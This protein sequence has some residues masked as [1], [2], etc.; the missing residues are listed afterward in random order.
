M[1]LA[2]DFS[3]VRMQADAL[4][5]ELGRYLS[6]PLTDYH[7]EQLIKHA[8]DHVVRSCA[9]KRPIPTTNTSN[10]NPAETEYADAG[11]YEEEEV[12][13][14]DMGTELV[15]DSVTRLVN[16]CQASDISLTKSQQERITALFAVEP[17]R[18]LSD[19]IM[20]LVDMIGTRCHNVDLR[21]WDH[22]LVYAPQHNQLKKE[23][24][25]TQRKL[26]KI[27]KIVK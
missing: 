27:R 7:W 3:R 13:I 14:T 9:A 11:A 18:D 6:T 20:V 1:T 8:P 15:N 19:E 17:N 12:Q 23:L 22:L 10:D 26:R 5:H 16:A 21:A 25:K 24:A 2:A 4:T